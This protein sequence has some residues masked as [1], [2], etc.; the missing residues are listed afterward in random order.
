MCT[1]SSRTRLST[2]RAISSRTAQ[3]DGHANQGVTEARIL[4]TIAAKAHSQGVTTTTLGLGLGYDEVLMTGMARGGSGEHHFAEEGDSAGRLIAGEVDGL[5]SQVA[6]AASLIVRPTGDVESVRVWNDLPA[7][8]IE[9]GVMIE[10]GDFYGGEERKLVLS[11]KVL[12]MP[13]LELAKVAD[14]ELRWVELPAAVEH[15]VEV[16]LHVNLVP[17]DEA[18]GRIPDPTVRSELTFQQAQ[19]ANAAPPTPSVK[20]TRRLRRAST[21]RRARC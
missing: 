19:D 9:D 17:G 21:A 14:L 3:S 15:T 10:P 6:Q 5:L 20:A 4:E 13:A 8:A 11:L 7:A 16:P 1:F 18:A 12:A 2:L